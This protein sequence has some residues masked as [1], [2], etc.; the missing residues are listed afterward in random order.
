MALLNGALAGPV[1]NGFV[2]SR[3]Q[4]E[5][6]EEAARIVDPVFL[7]SP[8]FRVESLEQVLGCR[9]VLK[10]EVLNPVRS[11]KGRGACYIASEIAPGIPLV[12]ASAGNFGQALAYACRARGIEL[13]VFAS[14]NAD[15]FKVERMRSFGA[16]VRLVG[17]DFD[18]AKIAARA[19]SQQEG[20]RFVEDSRDV[21]TCEGAGTIGMELL[22]WP[23]R[24]TAVLA[25]LGNGALLTG[26]ARWVKAHS[27]ETRIIGVCA[28][29]AP[30][31]AESWRAGRLVEHSSI[32]TIAAGI[33][34][35]V[36]VP[37][38][39]TDMANLVDEVLLVDDEAMVRAMKLLHEHLGLVIEP[40]GAV[41]VATLLVAPERFRQTLSA[42][43]LS[44]GNLGA[45]EIRR[46]LV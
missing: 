36:P 44:G 21:A 27:P 5:R 19:F 12:C 13:I 24:L 8:Q 46:W 6:I 23:E 37:E 17:I 22:R 15:K 28:T 3:L 26:V 4:L 42:V 40:S 7:Q 20:G 45:E 1:Q 16:E 32:T 43:V 41:G 35:R 39:L 14:V 10:V 25:P 29:G 31:M 11:F 38:V 18:A 34:V 9:V 30:A 2:T 33:G